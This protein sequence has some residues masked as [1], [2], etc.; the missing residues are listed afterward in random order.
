M[1]TMRVLTYNIHK[2]F[3][4][5]P[6]RFTLAAMREE[7]RAL[8]PDLMLLQ[9]V[10]GRHERKA[11]RVRG[12]PEG[13]QGDFL[14]A[15]RW[16][17]VVYGRNAVYDHGH[18]GNAILSKHDLPLWENIDIS[19]HALE[20]RGLL[21]AVMHAPGLARDLHLI[22]LHLDL[23]ARGRK[24]QVQRLAERVRSAVPAE[25]PLLIAGDLNDYDGRAGALLEAE[26]GLVEIHKALHGRHGATFPSWL[27][28]L[29][30]DRIYFRGLVPRSARTLTGKPWSAL[31][32]HGALIAEL[33]PC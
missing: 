13:G 30:L 5:M 32:D 19:N 20:R 33:A 23:T 31:S 18:H 8:D 14:A 29:P 15:A 24:R 16:P 9:E 12:W 17:H 1:A 4:T 21:H 3:S 2:G 7:L 10:Q 28:L 26:L 11:R 6:G 27:P 25:A 22:C